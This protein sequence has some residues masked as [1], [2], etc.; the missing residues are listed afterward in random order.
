VGDGG[1]ISVS[2]RIGSMEVGFDVGVGVVIS[3]G[4]RNSG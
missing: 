1:E 4:V 3:C 2:V